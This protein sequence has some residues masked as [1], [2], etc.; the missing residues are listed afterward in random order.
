MADK[1][2]KEPDVLKELLNGVHEDSPPDLEDLNKILYR[3]PKEAV[4]PSHRSFR[5]SEGQLGLGETRD[6]FDDEEEEEEHRSFRLTAITKRKSTIYFTRKMHSRLKYA[7]YQLRK[8]VG[9]EHRSSISMSDIVNNA[10]RI[11]LHEFEQKNDKSILLKMT[12]KNLKK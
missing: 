2:T 3:D 5:L 7:K 4:H 8:L 10:L 9:E 1:A 12:L 6:L 11:V